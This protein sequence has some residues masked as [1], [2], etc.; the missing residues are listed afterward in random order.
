MGAMVCDICGGKLVMNAGGIAVCDS[1]GMEYSKERVREKVQEIKGTVVVDNT[2]LIKNYF[3]MANVAFKSKNYLEAEN[4]CNKI[5]EIDSK[6]YKAWILKSKLAVIKAELE[7][8]AIYESTSI[9]KKAFEYVPAN[10]KNKIINEEDVLSIIEEAFGNIEKYHYYDDKVRERLYK[11]LEDLKLVVN[12]LYWLTDDGVGFKFKTGVIG[13]SM[14]YVIHILRGTLMRI[15]IPINCAYE[16][17]VVYK[18]MF[19][20]CDK[21]DME[22]MEKL[23]CSLRLI[24][25]REYS[26]FDL[27]GFKRISSD[28]VNKYN[29]NII[30]IYK[31]IMNEIE[32][33]IKER[34][35][36]YWSEH[37]EEK[38]T[39]EKLKCDAEMLN[40]VLADFL[41]ERIEFKRN[42]TETKKQMD[43]VGF[44]DFKEKNRLNKIY[45]NKMYLLNTQHINDLRI[46]L[47]RYSK[48]MSLKDLKDRIESIIKRIDIGL[49]IGENVS[50]S[51][52]DDIENAKMSLTKIGLID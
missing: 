4:Y 8:N 50:E 29:S 39:A 52:I 7:N 12:T 14:L 38:Q 48:N 35:K 17:F 16:Y 11:T 5:I 49:I 9:L 15:I 37:K 34:G 3:E 23:Y 26:S 42:V 22:N 2:P 44:F 36:K 46:N 32:P 19:D 21:N 47:D 28:D 43:K 33:P 27:N 18:K 6:N 41:G 24:E 10:E 51:D 45:E 40:N 1:C 31:E 30:N 25:N 20:L 13:D